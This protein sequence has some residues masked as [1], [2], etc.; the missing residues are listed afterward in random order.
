MLDRLLE[1]HGIAPLDL[2][3]SESSKDQQA[4]PKN[5]PKRFVRFIPPVADSYVLSGKK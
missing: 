5:K 4:E 2:S 3:S 1:N